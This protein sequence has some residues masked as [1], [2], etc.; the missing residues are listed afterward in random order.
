MVLG[1]LCA[2]VS[3]LFCTAMHTAN[4]LYQKYVPNLV[5]RGVVGG[6]IVLVLTLLI[7]NQDYNGAG[8]HVI[9]RAM[10]GTVVPV[11]SLLK[12]LLTAITLGAGFKGGEIVPVFFVGATF[13]CAVAPL[14]GL[15]PSFGAAAGLVA[16]FCGVV[17]C[18]IASFI[19]ALEL[20]GSQGLVLFA[21]CVSISYMISGYFGLYHDQRFLYSKY[22]PEFINQMAK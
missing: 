10:G 22:Q 14:L 6:L 16:V 9:I 17:N 5:L 8:M 21:L 20:F 18:P 1:I 3:V 2:L 7:G 12:L 15:A 19:L 13:G 11:A 4:K